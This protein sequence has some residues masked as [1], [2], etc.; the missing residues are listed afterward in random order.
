[1]SGTTTPATQVLKKAAIDFSL[2]AY[3]YDPDADRV[4][5][6]AAEAIGA[7]PGEVFKTLMIMLDGKPVCAVVPSDREVNMKKLAK[8]FAGKAAQM[9]PPPDAE[10]LTGYKVGG[11]SPLGQRRSVRTVLDA[12]ALEHALIYING[13]R[14]GYQIRMAPDHLV[15]LLGC[16]TADLVR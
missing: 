12:K 1:M 16:P 5:L 9:M 4:G 6:Q 11:I 10:R 2:V 7:E 13:G 8:A 3:D 14:R 15:D